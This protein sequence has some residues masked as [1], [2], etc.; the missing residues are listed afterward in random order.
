[1]SPAHYGAM[2][3]ISDVLVPDFQVLGENVLSEN[4][5]VPRPKAAARI[6]ESSQTANIQIFPQP[7]IYFWTLIC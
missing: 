5:F 6:Q 2:I 3:P 7:H 4:R 1:M